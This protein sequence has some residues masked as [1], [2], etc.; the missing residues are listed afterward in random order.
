MNALIKGKPNPPKSNKKTLVMTKNNT[1]NMRQALL[2]FIQEY[3]QERKSFGF[4]QQ[5]DR[6]IHRAMINRTYEVLKQL[7]QVDI[8]VVKNGDIPHLDGAQYLPERGDNFNNRF[9]SALEDT[10]SLGYDR[11][12]AIGSDIPTLHINDLR[13]AFNKN[14]MV[15]GPTEDG[16]FYL[17]ALKAEDIHLFDH[18][19]WRQPFL[20]KVLG[21]RIHSSGTICHQ[22]PQRRDIDQKADVRDSGNL[23]ML[24]VKRLL[25]STK[26]IQLLTSESKHQLPSR[27][28][29]PRFISL[30]PP[31]NN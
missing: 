3:S 24:L 31:V 25:S 14:E 16:G 9:L 4:G 18:L 15:L 23:L 13:S 10:F 8:I 26:T 20:L 7:N 12:V 29:A 5:L 22:L 17:A 1:V 28:P 2:L 6:S 30:P 11:V 27:I 21:E 19:P